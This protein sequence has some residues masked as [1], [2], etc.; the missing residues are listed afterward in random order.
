VARGKTLQGGLVMKRLIVV[1]AVLLG[2]SLCARAS[3]SDDN[4]F[5]SASP[6]DGRAWLK[7][8]D[9][10]KLLYLSGARDVAVIA[11]VLILAKG[12]PIT[13]MHWID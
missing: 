9:P 6:L 13:L 11:P 3:D 10:G 12:G 5:S 2:I 1:S 7:L 8:D 4:P